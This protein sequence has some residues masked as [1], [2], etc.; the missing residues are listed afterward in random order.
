MR[1]VVPGKDAQISDRFGYLIVL[2]ELDEEAL[3]SLGRN[4]I[5]NAV[6]IGA[7]A[8]LL[9]RDLAQIGTEN[10]NPGCVSAIGKIL[11]ENDG[12]GINLFSRSAAGDPNSQRVLKC[13]V[14]EERRKNCFG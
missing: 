7:G 9:D 10:L 2:V 14:L 11:Q 5:C 6:W 8:G 3:Q 4:F 1:H 13:A 12:D